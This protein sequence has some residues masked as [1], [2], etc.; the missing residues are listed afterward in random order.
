MAC[1]VLGELPTGSP[2]KRTAGG[3]SFCVNVRN[4]MVGKIKR[5]DANQ[6]SRYLEAGARKIGSLRPFFFST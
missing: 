5:R 3:R 2:V 1:G 4:E 6:Q